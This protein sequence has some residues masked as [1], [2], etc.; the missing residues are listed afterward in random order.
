MKAVYPGSFDPP[1]L[2]HLDIIERASKIFK[3]VLVL[4]SENPDKQ[5]KISLE[6]RIKLLEELASTMKNVKVASFS[7]LTVDYVKKQN[8]DVL[9]RAIRDSSDFEAELGMSQINQKLSG[10]ETLFFMTDPQYSFIR[11]S[12]V[13]EL[14]K[15]DGDISNM[16]P[17]N[18]KNHLLKKLNKK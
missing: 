18:V 11:S 1:T 8:Y 3:E 17:K 4:V 5:G 10:I 14:I 9:L 7:G 12:R 6:D 15:F 13:W 2:G 16:V